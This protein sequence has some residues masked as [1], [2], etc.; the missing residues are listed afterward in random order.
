MKKIRATVC[1]LLLCAMALPLFAACRNGSEKTPETEST[2]GTEPVTSAGEPEGLDLL[3]TAEMTLRDGVLSC[4][5]RSSDPVFDFAGRIT[6]GKKSKWVLTSD[7]AGENTI[8]E[9]SITLHEGENVCYIKVTA[10]EESKMYQAVIRYTEAYSVRFYANTAEPIPAQSVLPGAAAER[11]ADPVRPGYRFLGWYLDGAPYQFTD[12]VTSDRILIS[13]WEKLSDEWTYSDAGVHFSDTVAQMAVVWKDYGNERGVRPD[14]VTCLLTE[15]DGNVEKSYPVTVEKDKVTWGGDRPAAGTLS[16]GEGGDWTVRVAGLPVGKS[17]SFVQLP[18]G[19]PYATQQVGTTAVNTVEGYVPAVD[20]TAALTTRNARLYDAAGNLVVLQGVVT[21]N[22]GVSGFESDLS[23]S[24]LEKLKAIG[25]NCVR[26][27]VQL[28]GSSETGYVYRNNGSPRTGDYSEKDTRATE[29]ERQ[30]MLRKLDI[31]VTSATRLGM[32]VIVDWGILT[33]DPNQ[34]L[35]DAVGF[36]GTLAGKYAKN[37]YVLFEICNEPVATWGT[38]NGEGKS[39]R[40]YGEAVIESIR[41]AGSDAVVILAPNNS[42]THISNVRGDDPIHDPLDD[43]HAWNVAYTFHCYPGNYTFENS[44][45]CYG[46]RLR[47]AHEAGLTVIVTEFSPMDG[48]F[49]TA[50]PLSFDMRETAKYLRVFREWDIGYCYFRFASSLSSTAVYHENLMFRPFI[51][52]ALYNW[53]EADL[54]ECGKWYYRLVTG[55]GVLEVPDYTTEPLK[56]VRPKFGSVFSDYGLQAVFPG[57]AID[58]ERT[59]DVWCFITGKEATLSD[60]LYAGYCRAV[61]NKAGTISD[62]GKVYRADTSAIYGED[63]LPETAAVPFEATYR[64]NG[65]SVSI[66]IRFGENPTGNGYGLLV[67]I[68]YA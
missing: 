28:V 9:R 57:F 51:D 35:A 42:A 49:G 43:A 64:Y 62:T 20:R 45:Y 6:V 27:T 24:S 37:P 52:L 12:P 31:A 5:V 11:P 61:W 8:K 4:N 53:T 58:G 7:A 26:V 59:G 14:R 23:V 29:S 46:W 54:T 39:I 44:A 40:K 56:T 21:L 68:R 34:Y 3:T 48:T 25:T 19:S 17:Y 47:D 16:R 36:F 10:Q 65:R 50:D 67:A 2:A 33:S 13:Y 22:V 55:D 18:A 15:R 30:Q 60:A 63:D 32:Y 66:S 38:G 1:L 41:A